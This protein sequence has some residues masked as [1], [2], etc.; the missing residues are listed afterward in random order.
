MGISGSTAWIC[1]GAA[2]WVTACFASP[3]GWVS[4]SGASA[5]SSDASEGVSGSE[6]LSPDHIISFRCS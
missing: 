1:W 5:S 4:A 6:G 3:W 2:C